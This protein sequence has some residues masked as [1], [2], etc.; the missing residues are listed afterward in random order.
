[1][2]V[3]SPQENYGRKSSSSESIVKQIYSS[4]N[5]DIPTKFS[6]YEKESYEKIMGLIGRVD[7]RESGMKREVFEEFLRKVY[8]RTK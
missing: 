7:E 4:P 5:I 1:M 2:P 3:S 6:A 8:K